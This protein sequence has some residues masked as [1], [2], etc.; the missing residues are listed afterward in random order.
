MRKIILQIYKRIIKFFSGYRIGK[1][2]PIKIIH[3]FIEH[4]LKQTFVRVD[5]H[6]MFLDS[7]DS[8]GLSVNGI[9]ESLETELV[10]K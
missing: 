4:H 1:L 5:G 8:L 2:Y 6:K 7:K 3:G 10:K 9:F